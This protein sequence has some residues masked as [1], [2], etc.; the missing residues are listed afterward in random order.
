MPERLEQG[1]GAGAGWLFRPGVVA[2]LVGGSI[3]LIVV[4]LA[5]VPALIR[6]LPV[7]Y[8][9]AAAPP[10]PRTARAIA[11]RVTRNVV[12]LTL[13]LLGAAMLVLPGQGI[14]TIAAGLLWLE[15]P[16]RRALLRRI[17][18]LPPLRRAVDALRRDAGL[19]P[20]DL[21]SDAPPT[22]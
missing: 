3:L 17:V 2:A 12:G 10:R 9:V 13:V 20:L 6:R 14:L 4:S 19:A 5:L 21:T 15:F 18:S 8:L 11:A 22:P 7:D 16:G 1:L